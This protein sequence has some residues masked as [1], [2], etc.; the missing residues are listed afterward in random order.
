MFSIEEQ[1]HMMKQQIAAFQEQLNSD[2]TP[3]KSADD[4]AHSV[5]TRLHNDWSLSDTLTELVNL[6]TPLH[7]SNL[8]SD[9][10]RRTIIEPYP[11]MTHLEYKAPATIPTAERLM[12]K[13]QR[14]EDRSL[15]H[16]Q[17]L[18]SAAFLPLD[19]L[20]HDLVSSESGNPNLK[21]YC[22]MLRDISRK[23]TRE[24]TVN[25]RQHCRFTSSNSVNSSSLNFPDQQFFRSGPPSQ[26]D[27][28]INNNHGNNNNNNNSIINTNNNRPSKR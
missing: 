19:I 24:T 23:A 9:S 10:E 5:D 12:N 16:L 8:L 21:R 28:Y 26:Q 17:Y 13:G 4:T 7:T 2:S 11:L 18:L 15:K 3:M 20:S 6:D 25:R 27:G 1:P 22:T 14:Y